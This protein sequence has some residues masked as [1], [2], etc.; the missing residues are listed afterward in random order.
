MATW[1]CVKQCGACCRLDPSDRPDLHE[2]LSP[3]E[4]ALYLS[5]VGEDGWCVHFNHITRE[6]GI[7]VDRPRFCR[8]EPAV[9]HDLFGVEPEALNEFAIACCREQIDGVYG[10]RSLEMLR[11]DR[12]IGIELSGSPVSTIDL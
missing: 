12:E 7:Y 8:V 11:F 2:Y 5:L 10:D 6:C 4:L 9:F 3:D 1:R